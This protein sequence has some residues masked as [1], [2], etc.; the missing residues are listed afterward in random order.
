MGLSFGKIWQRMF[1]LNQEARIL[2]VGLDAAGKTTILYKF[3]LGEVVTTI[4][5]VGFNVETVTY[6]NI[7]LTMWD[8][9]GQD[10]IRRLWNYYFTN[11]NAII[12]VVDSNDSSRF[13][14]AREEIAKLMR[15][16]QLRDAA[17]LV[18]ANKQD[19]PN[20]LSTQKVSEALGLYNI[21][22]RDWYIQGTCA[23][24]GDGLYEGL[25][26]ICEALKK[27]PRNTA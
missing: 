12:F 16:D 13:E 11:V 5:T 3:Q 22:T 6:K 4:P 14:E 19:L 10:K 24:V 17:L 9:G 23:T 2:M 7:N 1:N 25:D 20:A 18:Y 21:R 15:D 8:V 26:W 27:R